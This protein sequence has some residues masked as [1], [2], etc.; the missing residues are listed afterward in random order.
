MAKLKHSKLKN[1]QILFELLTRQVAADTIRGTE[2]S[3][4]LR[5]IQKYYKPGTLL[6][7]EL[8]LYESLSRQRYKS[9]A[10]AETLL[11]E[12]LKVRR[13]I[14]AKQLTE[15]KYEL[16]KEIKAK[17][18]LDA[19]TRTQLPDY[20]LYASIYSL[21]ES[22]TKAKL[23]PEQAVNCRFTIIEHICGKST[24]KEQLQESAKVLDDFKKETEEVRLLAYRLMIETFNKKYSNLTAQQKTLLREYI[25]NI[26]NSDTMKTVLVANAEQVRKNITKLLPKVEDRVT[27]IK[28]KEIYKLTKKYD[29]VKVVNENHVLAMLMYMEL[30]K[31]LKKC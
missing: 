17:Y 7:K 2:T 19:F 3:P 8:G 22:D 23:R 1:T 15:A 30:V 28:L 18:S 13:S 26:A 27:A 6:S 24:K 9:E 12:V 21:F 31:E 5:L 14:N 11:R 25:N 10:K 16:V 29:D 20:K 4:A